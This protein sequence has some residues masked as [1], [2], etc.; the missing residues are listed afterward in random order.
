MPLN[1]Q[2]VP[3]TLTQ[4]QGGT[5]LRQAI[6]NVSGISEGG[7]S[8]YGFF[9][10]FSIRGLDVNFLVNG[11]FDAPVVMG[12]PRSLTGVERIEVL[13]G[14]GSA[15]FG[16]GTPG[17]TI[18]LVR[19]PP[20]T[21]PA[22]YLDQSVGSFKT[23]ETTFGATGPTT[24]PGLNY[25]IDGAYFTSE[26]FRGLSR[27]NIEL[28]PSFTWQ[29]NSDHLV[30]VNLDLRHLERT[31]DTSGIL[32]RGNSLL[33]VPRETRYYTPFAKGNQ[34]IARLAVTDEWRVS[35]FL[36]I[37]NRFSFMHRDLDILRNAGGRVVGDATSMTG[38]I[39]RS[40]QDNWN[41]VDYQFEPVWRF[42]T[43]S[44][45]HTLLTGFEVQQHNVISRRD[46]A[47]LP[48]ITDVFAPV[49]PE[50]SMAGLTFTPVYNNTI[51]ATYASFYAQDQIDVTDRLKVRVGLRYD[52]FA[53][54]LTQRL[55]NARD[56]REDGAVSYNAGLVYHLTSWFSPFIGTSRSNFALLST[57]TL[58]N[59][60][61]A[62]EQAT[63]YEGGIRLSPFGNHLIATFSI[64][65]TTRENFLQTVG[66]QV[67]AIG[68]QRTRGFDIDLEAR[69][70]EGTSIRANYTYQDPRLTNFPSEPL[71]VGT[72]PFG[73]PQSIFNL[74]ITQDIPSVPGLKIAGGVRYR[75][76]VFA[77]NYGTAIKE[78]HSQRVLPSYALV[79]AVISYDVKPNF[80]ISAG[81]SNL[82][83]Q[84]YYVTPVN[85]GA[86]PGESR[87]FF[88][89]GRLRS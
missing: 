79:D 67:F 31:P 58:V 81:V 8:S 48:N 45:N 22:Y 10:R 39:L 23:Y 35:D 17:G 51:D 61:R 29:P 73:I 88:L 78:G 12:Y 42:A 63:Q 28:L 83:D 44:I 65:E 66:T 40:Q 7:L 75:D 57:E 9:D 38:R 50:Q 41:D 72:I 1:I 36:T 54:T 14:P 6:R 46:S 59:N 77:E 21:V 27:E 68:E 19:A 15:L 82:F 16:S 49:I 2:T 87:T 11:L 74:W 64:F 71:S 32:F 4:E 86:L 85:W 13:K 53:T 3:T 56:S 37:N 33:P 55:S 84:T 70:F 20:S 89:R 69:P 47:N 5:E 80:Q 62:P 26:G 76:R 18:N 60:I 43:G 24:A 52:D 30:T 34:D 25:R